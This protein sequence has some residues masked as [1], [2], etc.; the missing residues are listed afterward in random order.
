[1]R[2]A[3]IQNIEPTFDIMFLQ[4]LQICNGTET[5][6][7]LKLALNIKQQIFADSTMEFFLK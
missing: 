1:M 6:K 4:T 5:A 3:K 2:S 7:F